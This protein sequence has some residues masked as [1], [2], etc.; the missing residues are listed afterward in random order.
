VIDGE[1]GYLVQPGDAMGLC[2]WADR[3]LSD[4][5][6]RDR[7]GGAARRRARDEFSVE[8]MLDRYEALMR[9]LIAAAG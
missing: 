6:L 7:V 2:Q 3:V 4:P 9:D 5:A 1:T 8:R